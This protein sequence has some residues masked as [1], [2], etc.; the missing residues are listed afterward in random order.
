MKNEIKETIRDFIVKTFLRGTGKIGDTESLFEKEV[1]DSFGLLELIAFLEKKFK[2]R[3]PPG[4][5]TIRNFDSLDK[6]AAVVERKR[7][8]R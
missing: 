6:I 1:L 5:I 2:I 4:E 3:V 7:D 8:K